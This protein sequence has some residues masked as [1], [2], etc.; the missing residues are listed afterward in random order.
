MGVCSTFMKI[1]RSSQ[2]GERDASAVLLDAEAETV[3]S[4]IRGETDPLACDFSPPIG[5]KSS[6]GDA[7]HNQS[8]SSQ[9]ESDYSLAARNIY[10]VI[11]QA[12]EVEDVNG[13]EDIWAP[14]E[15]SSPP[16]QQCITGGPPTAYSKSKNPPP[17]EREYHNHAPTK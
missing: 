7:Y 17:R 4:S 15:P 3:Y 2:P 16:T 9:L 5:P 12:D 10:N 8:V 6:Q 14:E 11:R 13:D 1:P